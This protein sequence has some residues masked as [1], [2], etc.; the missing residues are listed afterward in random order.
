MSG[1]A[2]RDFAMGEDSHISGIIL[3]IPMLPLARGSVRVA[4]M[5]PCHN[6]ATLKLLRNM[7]VADVWR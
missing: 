2:Q 6:E 3:A 7:R 4:F 5:R 1:V